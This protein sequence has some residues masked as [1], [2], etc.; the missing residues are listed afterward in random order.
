MNTLMSGCTVLTSQNEYQDD[1]MIFTKIFSEILKSFKL[2]EI[3]FKKIYSVDFIKRPEMK[4]N[5]KDT[6]KYILD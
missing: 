4:Q 1:A 2:S 3:W 5:G 6:S